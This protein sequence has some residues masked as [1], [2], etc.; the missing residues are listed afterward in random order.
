MITVLVANAIFECCFE[1]PKWIMR[2]DDFAELRRRLEAACFLASSL[3]DSGDFLRV[4]PTEPGWWF[5][6]C[7][8]F[9]PIWGRFPFWLLDYYFSD[10]LKP[11]TSNTSKRCQ[12]NLVKE[13]FLFQ[14]IGLPKAIVTAAESSSMLWQWRQPSIALIGTPH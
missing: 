7:F 10:G 9:T 6:K 8:I 14:C 11:P 2:E 3:G 1:G 13:T 5:Q 12:V 4:H